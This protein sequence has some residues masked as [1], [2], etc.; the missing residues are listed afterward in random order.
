MLF[1]S[2]G[3]FVRLVLEDRELQIYGD[4]RQI[5]DFVFVDDAAD[6]FLRAGASDACNGEVFNVG[7]T[8]P[9]AH[10]DLVQLMIATA[11]SGRF[12]LVEWPPEKKAIDIGDFYA[13]SSRIREVLGW[14]PTTT[15]RDG[16]ARTFTYYRAHMQHYVPSTGEQVAAL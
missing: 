4:G 6:A 13:D 10:R 14:T 11:G 8:E 9:I 1:R 2:I 7:G 16:L 3:W 5:R 12:T 15:L